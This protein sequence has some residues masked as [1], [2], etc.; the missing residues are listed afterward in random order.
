MGLIGV[1]NMGTA[2]AERVLDGGYPLVVYNRT[3][4]KANA[5]GALGAVVV[6]TPAELSEQ[7]DV[8]LTSLPDDQALEDVAAD[9]V[10]A[11]RPGTVLADT[12]DGGTDGPD[13]RLD[14]LKRLLRA[15]DHEREVPRTHNAG[16]AADRRA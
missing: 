14:T 6:K 1:G 11:A 16:V 2:M 3:P 10:A 7:V 13:H 8:V 15:G 5:L 9:V 12:M 4:E